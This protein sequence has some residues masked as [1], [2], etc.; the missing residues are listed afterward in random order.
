MKHRGGQKS[1]HGQH[2]TQQETRHESQTQHVS[3]TGNLARGS[4]KAAAALSVHLL[5]INCTMQTY[6]IKTHTNI[7]HIYIYI[8]FVCAIHVYIVIIID[9][10]E[11]I[12]MNAHTHTT[13]SGRHISILLIV[14]GLKAKHKGIVL[15]HL[16][17]D[18]PRCPQQR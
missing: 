8:I 3:I 17:F 15:S 14:T 13:E 10:I 12:R 11:Y 16:I 18:I 4:F 5:I 9:N 1:K 6:T 2:E 7:W